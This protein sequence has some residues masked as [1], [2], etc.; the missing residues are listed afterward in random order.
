MDMTR[1]KFC[2]LLRRFA[3]CM[4]R[5]EESR[6]NILTHHAELNEA[7]DL[8]KDLNEMLSNETRPQ[9]IDMV[10]KELG[11]VVINGEEGSLLEQ[12][13]DSLPDRNSWS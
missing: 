12:P 8:E 7:L 6:S 4:H 11:H 5:S 1:Q 2:D 9:I 13:D 3:S 10:R